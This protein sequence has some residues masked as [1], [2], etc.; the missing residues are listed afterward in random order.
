MQTTP[1]NG[2][3]VNLEPIV[4]LATA[5]LNLDLLVT[6]HTAAGYHELDSVVVFADI[7]DRLTVTAAET[8]E[9]TLEGPFAAALGDPGDNL[10]LE[11]ARRL[12]AA[13]GV[14][15]RARI[16]LEKHLPV[17]SGIGGGSA[18]AA[19]TLRGLARLWDLDW[20]A[21][22]LRELGLGIGADIPVCVYGRPARLRG[23]GERLDPIRGLPDLPL[24]LV[25][26]GVALATA[27]V[28]RAFELPVIAVRRQALPAHPSLHR[29]AVWLEASRNELE[30][31]ACS[32]APV[33]GTVLDRLRAIGDCLLARMSGS[34]ATCFGLFPDAARARAAA[35]L[36]SAEAPGWWCRACIAPG[37]FR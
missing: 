23:I 2:R 8:L 27:A 28:F 24:V 25:N 1:E 19:A 16:T 4:E 11:A 18:D 36:I 26:P 13:A 33:I 32:L 35:E 20:P 31:A 21:D 3:G 22:R 5:K 17:A 30:P 6:G 37:T 34:G 10:V 14:A 12:A 7:G 15:P 9:L 29:L